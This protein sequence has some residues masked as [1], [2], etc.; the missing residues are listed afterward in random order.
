MHVTEHAP[1]GPF[2]L[3]ERIH[4]LAEIVERRAVVLD[5]RT[6]MHFVTQIQM[7]MT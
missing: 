4:G 7:L 3:L 2:Q 1:R 6:P 5:T